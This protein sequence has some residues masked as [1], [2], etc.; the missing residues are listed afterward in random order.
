MKILLHICCAPCAIYPLKELR[1]Q[2]M[3]VT[4]FFYNHNIHPYQEYRRRLD[5]VRVYAE[6]VD[7][8]MVYRDEYRLEEFLAAVADNPDQRC[9]YCYASRLEATAKAAAENGFPAF[10]SSLLYSRYQKHDTIRELGESIGARY[11]IRFH[12]DD[13]RRGWQEGIRIS[14]EV[15]LYRQQYCGCIYSEK[16]RYAPKPLQ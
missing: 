6:K 15:G 12:Y 14:R 8:A 7:L 1:S 9:I 5:T 3:E 11:G 2:G 10:T 4:G 16:E 13:F